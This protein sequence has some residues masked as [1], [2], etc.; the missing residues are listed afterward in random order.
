VTKGFHDELVEALVTGEVHPAWASGP[1]GEARKRALFSI[2]VY[3]HEDEDGRGVLFPI[4]RFRAV[5][6]W[7]PGSLRK[8]TSLLRFLG[9]LQDDL[10]PGHLV[11]EPY[12]PPDEETGRG[13]A[14]AIRIQGISPSLVEAAEREAV[15][16]KAERLV[17]PGTGEFVGV[18]RARKVA[19]DEALS[20][21]TF[22]E[23][24][25][26][27]IRRLVEYLHARPPRAFSKRAGAAAEEVAG[28]LARV[29]GHWSETKWHV[30]AGAWRSV[31]HQPVPVYRTS[32]RT[33]RLVPVGQGLANAPSWIRQAV[34]ADAFEVDMKAAQLALVAALWDV[35][36]IEPYL[37]EAETSVWDALVGHLFALFPHGVY[38]P[39][40]DFDTLKPILKT[41]MYQATFGAT[42]ETLQRFGNSRGMSPS[43]HR[44]WREGRARVKKYFAAKPDEVAVALLAHPV[45]EA[46]LE[47]REVALREIERAGRSV[48]VFG[49]EYVLGSYAEGELVDARSALAGE[50]QAAEAFVMLRVARP[51]VVEAERVATVKGRQPE[52]QI[53]LWQSDGLTFAPRRT[54][55]EGPWLE[56]AAE[57]LRDGCRD[58]EDATGCREVLTGLEVK[59]RP[60]PTR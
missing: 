3:P 52:A 43:E 31:F 50:V 32:E 29:K 33:Q 47:A 1:E 53:L 24:T 42:R 20:N 11:I 25:P 7:K 37:V 4:D 12:V 13:K 27:E 15:P 23:D 28:E 18:S 54:G 41:T 45:F 35:P 59:Y 38:D 26:L 49:R 8:D 46:L 51:F 9:D 34:L 10:P 57:G 19:R 48:D 55:G 60:T 21:A 39:E 17:R 44:A 40:V 56:R 14:T 16:R 6:G 36:E 2:L 5:M 22:A 30:H 58:L